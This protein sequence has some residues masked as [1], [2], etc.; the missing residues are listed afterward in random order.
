MLWD[1]DSRGFTQPFCTL[2]EFLAVRSD[3]D[4]KALGRGKYR[5]T[6][7]SGDELGFCRQLNNPKNILEHIQLDFGLRHHLHQG[8]NHGRK[9]DA[10][11]YFFFRFLNRIYAFRPSPSPKGK[12]HGRE[13]G[14]S[15]PSSIFSVCFKLWS[16]IPSNKVTELTLRHQFS[17]GRPDCFQLIAEKV[18]YLPLRQP[19]QWDSRIAARCHST[20]LL[21][22]GFVIIFTPRDKIVF[23][24]SHKMWHLGDTY[25]WE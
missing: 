2:F 8:P 20:E 18:A 6:N 19:S 5:D 24:S 7:T 25:A 14:I 9:S 21:S 22:W 1:N 16:K 11:T 4:E 23:S 10:P 3:E 15:P 17:T 13:S 12:N